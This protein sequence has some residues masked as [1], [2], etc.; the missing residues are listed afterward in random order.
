MTLLNIIEFTVEN[1]ATNVL[2]ADYISLS[3]HT[4]L[5]ITDCNS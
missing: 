5:A 3:V 4:F 2:T 1:A